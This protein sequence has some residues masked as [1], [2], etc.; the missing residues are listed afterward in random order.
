M[1][2]IL[3]L[4]YTGVVLMIGLQ[5]GMYKERNTLNEKHL[6]K[7]LVL[8]GRIDTCQIEMAVIEQAY[9]NAITPIPIEDLRAGLGL[10]EN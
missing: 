6:L 7:E 4:L 3:T 10:D 8:R 1:K 2:I 5:F 9:I